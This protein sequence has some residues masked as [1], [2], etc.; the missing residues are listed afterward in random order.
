[1]GLVAGSDV[2]LDP[3]ASPTYVGS[4][5][6]AP[7]AGRTSVLA[8][9]IL[10]KGRFDSGEQFSNPQVFD[11]V[12]THKLSDRTTYTADALYS[13]QR[14]VPDRGFVNNWG[15]VQYLTCQFAPLLSGTARLEFFGDPQG[16]KTGTEGCTPPPRP[17]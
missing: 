17:G 15:V 14:D 12:L 10:G 3:A 6:W 2:F 8:A 4:V 11:L 5:K 13:F 16:F 7:P 9:V 1:M